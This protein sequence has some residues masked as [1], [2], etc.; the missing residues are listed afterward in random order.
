MGRR[1]LYRKTAVLTGP[2]IV[3]AN[4]T[5]YLPLAMLDKWILNQSAPV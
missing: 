4:V 1:D 2:M 5:E 3:T